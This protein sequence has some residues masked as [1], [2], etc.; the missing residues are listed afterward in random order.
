M[1]PLGA[2]DVLPIG[3]DHVVVGVAVDV[4]G[5]TGADRRRQMR[6]AVEQDNEGVRAA[7]DRNR[8]Q[9]AVADLLIR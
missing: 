1:R 6:R 2:G 7:L 9:G 4:V 3:E 8:R 5:V